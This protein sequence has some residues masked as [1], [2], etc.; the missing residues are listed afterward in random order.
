MTKGQPIDSHLHMD[1]DPEINKLFNAAIKA[2]AS[3][4]HLKL[5]NPPKMRVHSKLRATSGEVLTEKVI[6]DLVFEILT[7]GQKQ[8]F[9]ENGALDFAW[10]VGT[11]DRFRI[12]IS[13]S[14]VQ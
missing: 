8:F 10:A 2:E 9:M 3:D 1:H 12:N 7:D 13:V 6:Q 11:A 5:G 4:L 14:E